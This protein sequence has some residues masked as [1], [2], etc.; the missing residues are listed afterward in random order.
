MNPCTKPENIA[1]RLRRMDGRITDAERAAGTAWYY[2]A[3]DIVEGMS[4]DYGVTV[5]V[6]AAVLA[7][8]S[9]NVRWSTNVSAARAMLDAW[10]NGEPQPTVAGYP[11][12]R[13]KAWAI[14][15]TGDTSRLSGPKVEAFAANLRGDLEYVTLDMWA[16]RAVGVD[17]ERVPRGVR[18]NVVKGYCRAAAQIGVPVAVFQA[19]IWVHVRGGAE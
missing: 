8:L 16:Y 12:N 13:N 10:Y 6:A 5:E 19:I 18:D 3:R 4:A 7:V 9:P 2:R 11:A 17:P 1:K 14:L 15:G